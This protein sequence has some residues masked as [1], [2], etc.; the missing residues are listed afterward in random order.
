MIRVTVWNENLSETKYEDVAAL[1]PKGIHGYLAVLFGKEADLDVR[2]ATMD[3]PENG[4]PDEVLENTDVLIWWA[5]TG[6]HLVSDGVAW[7]VQQR[8]LRGMGLI[9]LHS[10]HLSKPFQLLMGTSCTL[11][12]RD[13]D[14]ER[15]WTVL[16]N[17]PIAQ[18]V[19]EFIELEEEEMYG[20]RFD[21]PEPDELVFIGWFSGGEVFR[22]G[23]CWNRGLGRVF[24]FQPGHESNTAYFQAPIQRILLNAVRWAA[25]SS[26]APSIECPQ[27]LP[28]PEELRRQR[29]EKA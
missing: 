7:K 11:K 13:G 22:S 28:S 23:C 12:W 27:A 4:L 14:F 15:L 17:H 16:P 26:I 8:V 1:F 6:H 3:Q 20:E 9:V 5:H 24:Y 19:G 2:T 21:V 25:P 18:G 10:A 29:E